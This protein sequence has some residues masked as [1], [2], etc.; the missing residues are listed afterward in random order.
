MQALRILV[1]TTIHLRR[2]TVARL[3]S[4]GC[5]LMGFTL[6][7]LG[8]TPVGGLSTAHAIDAIPNRQSLQLTPVGDRPYPPVITTLAVSPSGDLLAAAGDDHA[9]RLLYGERFEQ[10]RIIGTHHDW[11]RSLDFSPDGQTLV[12]GGNDGRIQVWERA[13]QWSEPRDL[14]GGP[15]LACVCYNQSGNQIAAVGFAPH[16]F[17]LKPSAAPPIEL[18]CDCRDLR[19]VLFLD[20]DRTIAVGGRTGQ[21]HFFNALSGATI[22]EMPL[23]LGRLRASALVDDGRAIAS[24]GEDGACVVVDAA[25]RRQ[26]QRVVI[27]HCKLLSIATID[28]EHVAVG[29]SDNSI[30]IIN[31]A[32][33][34]VT[35]RLLGHTGSVAAL[36]VSKQ[37]LISGSYDTT[38]KF[39][40]LDSM[41]NQATIAIADDGE[42][43]MISVPAN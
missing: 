22:A 5:A 15:A 24:V 38:I 20:A 30:H 31:V 41:L 13:K 2:I 27:P 9:I 4:L 14:G 12:S 34:D 37:Q 40:Q 26:K 36:T 1:S 29:A 35:K 28:R 19:T 16:V 33:G 21:L 18:L 17:L 43:K 3:A 7:G 10:Q 25:L 6:V 32:R 39:W 8:I 23:H 11:V 42:K